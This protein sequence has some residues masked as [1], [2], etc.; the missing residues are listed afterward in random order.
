MAPPSGGPAAS[1]SAGRM[2]FSRPHLVQPAEPEPSV[3]LGARH[4]GGVPGFV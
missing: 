2:W 3:R 4:P 1:G